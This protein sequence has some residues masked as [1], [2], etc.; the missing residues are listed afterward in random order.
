MQRIN[1][2]RLFEYVNY[3]S[4]SVVYIV[5]GECRCCGGWGRRSF[6]STDLVELGEL[7]TSIS[8]DLIHIQ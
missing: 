4:G 7:L 1:R 8:P 3:A 6:R 2:L 5:F